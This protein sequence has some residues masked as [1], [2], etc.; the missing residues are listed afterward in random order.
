MLPKAHGMTA[1]SMSLKREVITYA[2][3]VGTI[4]V[5]VN[6]VAT[7]LLIQFDEHNFSKRTTSNAI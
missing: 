6:E 5:A 3:E 1:S 2:S 7:R 4:Y